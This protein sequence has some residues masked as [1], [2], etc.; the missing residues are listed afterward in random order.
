MAS[1][2]V[3]HNEL[4][5]WPW[6]FGPSILLDSCMFC[7]LNPDPDTFLLQS[8]EFLKYNAVRA[9]SFFLCGHTSP[10]LKQPNV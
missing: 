3:F 8:P 6:L 1:F 9:F 7:A 4:L 5:N 2:S 10:H